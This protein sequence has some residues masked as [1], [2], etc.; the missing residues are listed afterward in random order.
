MPSNHDVVQLLTSLLLD[1]K[2]SI[3]Q[4]IDILLE[5]IEGYEEKRIHTEQVISKLSLELQKQQ[6][7]IAELKIHCEQLAKRH[8]SPTLQNLPQTSFPFTENQNLQSRPERG[9]RRNNIV[10]TGLEV[11]GYDPKIVIENFLSTNFLTRNDAVLAV[12]KLNSSA[13]TRYL[14]T[15]KSV[16]DAQS[17]YSQRLLKLR[18]KNI[19]ISED[20]NQQ[21]ASIFYKARCL[22]KAN[23]IQS[24]WTKD[25]RTYIRENSTQDAIEFNLSHPLLK[26][27]SQSISSPSA[28]SPP[29]QS[30]SSSSA[31]SPPAQSVPSPSVISPPAPLQLIP[32]QLPT[33]YITPS[34][35][36]TSSDGEDEL[37]NLIEEALTGA[38]TR[39]KTKDKKNEIHKNNPILENNYC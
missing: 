14:V 21:E 25:G 34:A 19:F 6:N 28:I 35:P 32:I 15:L 36:E 22:K 38:I 29:A 17:I 2:A 30:I 27:P 18:N 26:H 10:I 33:S 11:E 8:I 31:I 20:L 9:I 13:S 12:Q 1:F 5:K 39:S 23:L 24:T 37:R 7:E 4:Q 16:W 3:S